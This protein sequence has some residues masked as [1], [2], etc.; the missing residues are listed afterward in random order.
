MV[1][2]TNS[3]ETYSSPIAMTNTKALSAA[4]APEAPPT[5]PPVTTR[6]ANQKTTSRQFKIAFAFVL[7]HL[8]KRRVCSVRSW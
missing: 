3:W 8:R 7:A 2:T 4:A 1:F 5:V 6:T